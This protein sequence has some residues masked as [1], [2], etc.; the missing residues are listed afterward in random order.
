MFYYVECW[1][2]CLL[3]VLCEFFE[4]GEYYVYV[5]SLFELGLL[6]YGEVMIFGCSCCEVLLSMYV[7]YLLMCNDNFFG[8][9]MLMMFVCMFG[10]VCNLCYIYCF[11][12]VLGMIGLIIWLVCNQDVVGCIVYG[13]VV[14]NLGDIGNFYYKCMLSSDWLIDG[15]VVWVFGCFGYDVQIELYLFF[16]YDE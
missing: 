11:V 9:F 12:F 7:C 8:I 6:I 5:D 3:Y 4:L 15:C 14:L 2:F 10:I 1:G 13:F 16:G